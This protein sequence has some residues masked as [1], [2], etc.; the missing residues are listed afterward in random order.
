MIKKSQKNTPRKS[1]A[2]VLAVPELARVVGGDNPG[3]KIKETL[4]GD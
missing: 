3:S 2:A 4:V 1:R